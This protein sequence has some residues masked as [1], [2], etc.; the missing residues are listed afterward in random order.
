[1]RQ[2]AGRKT[3]HRDEALTLR[4]RYRVTPLVYMMSVI[5]DPDAPPRRRAEMAKAAAPYLHHR[6]AA[7]E[8]NGE[9]GEPVRPKL[10]LRK[11]TDEE[12]NTFQAL[13]AK[14]TQGGDTD[15]E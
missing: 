1:M 3:I 10:D 13:V 7:I 9:D 8:V 4:R 6:L 2:G 5:N 15:S 12:L 14:A 11:L